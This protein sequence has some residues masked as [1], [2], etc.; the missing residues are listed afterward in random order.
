MLLCKL[1]QFVAR[2]TSPLVTR[3][4]C[5]MFIG[6]TCRKNMKCPPHALA[7]H[8]EI[9][10]FPLFL[11]NCINILSSLAGKRGPRLSLSRQN[12]NPGSEQRSEESM[13][14]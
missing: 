9:I 5:L 8:N 13:F 1:Q 10:L 7:N 6:Q 2:I 14:L 3:E 4:S 12:S 11:F